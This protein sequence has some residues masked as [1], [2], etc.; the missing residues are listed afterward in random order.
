AEDVPGGRQYDVLQ[1]HVAGEE[2]VVVADRTRADEH[3]GT[4]RH[5]NEDEQARAAHDHRPNRPAGRSASVSKRKPNDTAGAHD[6]PRKGRLAVRLSTIP[7]SSAA[8]S[9]PGR[10]PSPPST[11]IANT[12]PIYSRPI[13]GSTGWITMSS[14]PAIDAVA[15][16][17]AKAVRLMRVGE[18]AINRSASWSCAT[19]MMARPRKGPERNSCSPANNP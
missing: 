9:V 4:E 10:L 6:G 1:H 16:E 8:I 5:A 11:Q 14:A 13:E 7:S 18:A 12:R 19:A 3:D 15:I 2:H 17:S